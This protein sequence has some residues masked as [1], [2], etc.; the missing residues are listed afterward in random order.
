MNL[1]SNSCPSPARRRALF[2]S[3]LAVAGIGGFPASRL[4]AADR[5]APVYVG[6]DHADQAEGRRAL[7]E[8]RAAGIA[9]AYWLEYDLRVMPHRGSE[10]TLRGRIFG[11]RGEKGPLTRLSLTNPEGTQTWLIQSGPQPEAWSSPGAAPSRRLTEAETLQPI[12]GTDLALFDLQMPFL[13]WE[14]FVYEGTAKIRNRPAYSFLLYP[15]ADLAAAQPNLGAVRVAL[16]TQFHA[17]VQAEFLDGKGRELK[18][19]TVLDLKK[20]GTQWIVKSI[21]VRNRT[22]R[23]KTRFEVTAA[24]LDLALPAEVFSP[25]RFGEPASPPAGTKIE[26]F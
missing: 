4:A 24:A 5:P 7:E 12:S 11:T 18:S 23:D 10:R 19:I 20:V 21:D 2:W 6:G 9:G 17:L 26:R 1:P 22:T 3:L 16:D 25:E 8:F 14:D 13:Y 15:P